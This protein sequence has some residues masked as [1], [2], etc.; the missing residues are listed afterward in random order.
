MDLTKEK[1]ADWAIYG[2]LESVSRMIEGLNEDFP[3]DIQAK[4]MIE[5]LQ[6]LYRIKKIQEID[7]EEGKQIIVNDWMP[8]ISFLNL[9]SKNDIDKK[10]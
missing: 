3:N 8:K 2:S 7:F 10:N 1:F 6:E 5:R 4:L 9:P